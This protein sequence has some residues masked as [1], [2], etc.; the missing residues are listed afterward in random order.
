MKRL[1]LITLALAA[2]A[3]L[4]TAQTHTETR[5]S[6]IYRQAPSVDSSI[7]G[8]SIFSLMPSKAKGGKADVTIRQPHSVADAMSRQISDNPSRTISGFRIRI[9]FDNAQNARSASEETLKSF[10]TKYHG[11]PAYRSYQNPF[12]KV[13]V[14]DFRTKSEA[15]ELLEKIKGDFPAAF[16]L[17]ENINYPVIDK[18]HPYVVDTVKVQISKAL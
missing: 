2:S 1:L 10:L 8:K 5:D 17:K 15:L 12:F 9:F 7:V 11:I 16:I 13:T 14:G 18:A 4:A 3:A 6:V